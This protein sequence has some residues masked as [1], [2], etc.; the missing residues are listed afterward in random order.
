[1]L[2]SWK[3]GLVVTALLVAALQPV[4]V[5]EFV[6]YDDDVYVTDNFHV[7]T[8]LSCEN[9]RWAF[10]TFHGANWHPLTWLSHQ[11]DVSLWGM[12]APGH[13]LTS[14]LI[15][16][17]AALLLMNFLNRVTGDALVSMGTILLWA[18]HPMRVE[19]VA[20]IA[21]RKD[22]LAMLVLAVVLLAYRRFLERPGPGRALT[23]HGAYLVGCLTKPSL[24]ILPLLLLALDF[25][26]LGRMTGRS[27]AKFR[28]LTLEKVPLLLMAAASSVMTFVAQ[29][30]GGAVGAL[31]ILP[32]RL[33]LANGARS[34]MI[35]LWKTLFPRGLSVAHPHPMYDVSLGA[36]AAGL[37]LFLALSFLAYATREKYPAFTFGWAWFVAGLAPVLGI[38]QVGVQAWADRYMLIPHLGLAVTGSLGTVLLAKRFSGIHYRT[39]AAVVILAVAL[40]LGLASHLQAGTWRNSIDLF[41]RA[42][43]V[44]PGNYLAHY[45]LGIALA[46]GDDYTGAEESFREA[47]G[48]VPDWEQ[49][50]YQ[51]GLLYLDYGD[52]QRAVEQYRVLRNLSP[53]LADRFRRFLSAAGI[54]W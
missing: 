4:L 19:S 14:L 12:N 42:V 29:S 18:L 43:E 7:I 53:R 40:P 9:L 49:A 51:L 6:N 24:V 3:A 31:D 36:A 39:V 17:L 5:A 23:L 37:L 46:K 13:H 10:G 1:M 52:A 20:W 22:M 26:P 38:V 11:A 2:K 15:F 33:R 28:R 35:Y 8:G 44:D 48:I 54:S 45:N 30:K 47:L 50:H 25:W 27:A 41:R 34:I 21:E 16:I 32:L